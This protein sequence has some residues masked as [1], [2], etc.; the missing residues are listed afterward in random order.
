MIVLIWLFPSVAL[1]FSVAFLFFSLAVASVSIFKNHREAY[2]QGKITRGVFMRNVVLEMVGILLA[3]ILA[4]LLG[5]YPAQ[6]A[7]AQVANEFGRLI[8]GIIVGVLTGVG[9]GLLVKK[10]WGRLL[11]T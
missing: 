7:T 11:K 4:G 9:I 5:R 8:T 3:I 10:T 1:M 2:L 6:I